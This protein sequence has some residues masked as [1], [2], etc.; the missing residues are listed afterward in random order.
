MRKDYDDWTVQQLQFAL[1]EEGLSDSGKKRVLIDRLKGRSNTTFSGNDNAGRTPYS[2]WKEKIN[3][4]LC[5]KTYSRVDLFN[6]RGVCESCYNDTCN[7]SVC[8]KEKFIGEMSYITDEE[9][10]CCSYCYFPRL[11]SYLAYIPLLFIFN[12]LFINS[13]VTVI[14]LIIFLIL[15]VSYVQQEDPFTLVGRFHDRILLGP[16]TVNKSAKISVFLAIL[17]IG[18]L[19]ASLFSP[20]FVYNVEY[21]YYSDGEKMAFSQDYYFDRVDIH[22]FDYNVWGPAYLATDDNLQNLSALSR[23]WYYDQDFLTLGWNGEDSITL[24][25][26]SPTYDEHFNHRQ[27]L[28][29]QIEIII[30]ISISFLSAAAV[31]AFML[32]RATTNLEPNF[33]ELKRKENFQRQIA[34]FVKKVKEMRYQNIDILSLMPHVEELKQVPSPLTTEN[35]K[36][37]KNPILIMKMFTILILMGLIISTGVIFY[38]ADSWIDVSEKDNVALQYCNEN[39]DN[40]DVYYITSSAYTFRESCQISTNIQVLFYCLIISFIITI[41]HSLF[42]YRASY[43]KVEESKKLKE[44]IDGLKGDTDKFIEELK[45]F[46]KSID[47]PSANLNDI[48]ESVPVE[49]EEPL[50]T[51]ELPD[52]GEGLLLDEVVESE[53]ESVDDEN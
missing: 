34:L 9:T 39:R 43:G 37:D 22:N 23:P 25:Y 49:E 48:E 32:S 31:T 46:G 47:V 42:M 24:N 51:T 16:T 30:F 5:S 19:F 35:E 28:I 41:S 12:F 20:W 7:C 13:L 18:L 33:L 26:N 53:E 52:P 11:V 3:C 36:L 29:K 45:T 6:N 1:R 38:F 14:S 44:K 10:I 15:F 21:N 17:L 2:F 40:E 27:E 8:N 50:T 4:P